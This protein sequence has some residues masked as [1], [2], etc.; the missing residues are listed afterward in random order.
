[1]SEALILPI[2]FHF[3]PWTLNMYLKP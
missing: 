3:E 2:A 1:V